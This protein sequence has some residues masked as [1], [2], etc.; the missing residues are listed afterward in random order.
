MSGELVLVYIN[1]H[2]LVL[3]KFTLSNPLK[4]ELDHLIELLLSRYVTFCILV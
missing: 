1:K 2:P 3:A 4:L